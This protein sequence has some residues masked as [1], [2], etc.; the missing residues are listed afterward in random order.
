MFVVRENGRETA[1]PFRKSDDQRS[2][3]MALA[4]AMWVSLGGG[5][6]VRRSAEESCQPDFGAGLDRY[7]CKAAT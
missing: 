6:G 2:A 4:H 7:A 5:V 1:L 3:E